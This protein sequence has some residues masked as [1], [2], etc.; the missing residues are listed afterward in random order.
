MADYLAPGVYT[1]GNAHFPAGI[2]AAPTHITVFIGYTAYHKFNGQSAFNTPIRITSLLE[3]KQY[4]GGDTNHQFD[5]NPATSA[6]APDVNLATKG[7]CVSQVTPNFLLYRSLCL[8]FNNGGAECYVV[9]VGDYNSS[10][11]LTAILAGLGTIKSEANSSVIAIPDAVALDN[12]NEC[13]VVQQSLLSQCSQATYKRFAILDIFQGDSVASGAL[14]DDCVDVFRHN[15]AGADLSYS[16]AYYPW[17]ETSVINSKELGFGFFH[18]ITRLKKLLSIELV[19]RYPRAK[20]Q[21]F[22]KQKQ[23]QSLI[24]AIAED[25]LAT[26]S[27]LQRSE[28][29]QVHKTLLSLSPFYLAMI[30][31]ITDKLNLLPPSGAVCGS[32]AMVDG[33]RGVWKA[34][35]NIALS[36]V[37][38][39]CQTLSNEQQQE[40]NADP[41]GKSINAIR[42]FIGEGVLIWGARTL[43][44]NDNE[45]RYINVRRTAMMIEQSIGNGLKTLVF[46][47]NDH[48]LWSK[49]KLM[50]ESFLTQLWQQG[51]LA[52]EKPEQAFFVNVGLNNS[53]TST[54]ILAG[55]FIV[56]L[57]VAMVRP[58]EFTVLKVE[59]K[60]SP[61]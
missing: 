45:W 53:M 35:A 17:L 8:F 22:T 36:S 60:M 23:M 55:R 61:P 6:Q 4:F 57:G 39:P 7:Y 27:P 10:I 3:F 20:R 25:N 2:K 11:N 31:G 12:A 33:T 18:N 30:M 13:A 47:A 16:A 40:L 24:A 52:G 58:G 51:A 28:Q 21:T 19:Q 9:S 41:C 50:I 14:Q 32:Y 54:D 5:I 59:Q 29:Q 49:T 38:R 34:P 48:N 46:A 26:L 56:Q 15:I 44:G 43:A 1:D 42:S 37:I